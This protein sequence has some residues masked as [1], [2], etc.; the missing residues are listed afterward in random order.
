MAGAALLSQAVSGGDFSAA[1]SGRGATVT[2][3]AYSVIRADGTHGFTFHARRQGNLGKRL[4]T[5]V[6]K[7][8]RFTTGQ[9]IS[10]LTVAAQ[11]HRPKHIRADYLDQG[12]G[13]MNVRFHT[14]GVHSGPL[15]ANCTGPQRRVETGVWRGRIEYHGAHGF[16]NVR[17]DVAKGRVVHEVTGVDCHPAGRCRHFTSTNL[18]VD[19]TVK[20]FVTRLHCSSRPE[21]TIIRG[22]GGRGTAL[23]KT[24]ERL[25]TFNAHRTHA[26]VRLPKGSIGF[27]GTAT[28][29]A[30]AGRSSSEGAVRGTLGVK[31]PGRRVASIDGAPATLSSRH[32]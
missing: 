14:T 25:F 8:N 24:K 4:N 29:N 28:F 23:L 15:P 22:E 30:A 21:L 20:F 31:L 17:T 1:K 11:I 26:T 9:V 12:G 13:A 10:S 32:R 18:N 3:P 5:K 6:S 19:S 16:T 7:G 27:A 2:Y